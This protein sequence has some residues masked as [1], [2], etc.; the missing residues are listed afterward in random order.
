MKAED[1]YAYSVSKYMGEETWFNFQQ[2]QMIFHFLW[3]RCEANHSPLFPANSKNEYSHTSILHI[4]MA[5]KGTTLLLVL[6]VTWKTLE[7]H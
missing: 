7:G 4:F 6:E 3:Q 5:H 2:G 1:N